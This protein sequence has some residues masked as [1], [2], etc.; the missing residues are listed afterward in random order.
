MQKSNWGD[1]F[2]HRPMKDLARFLTT[3]NMASQTIAADENVYDIQST[4]TGIC[5]INGVFIE[6]LTVDAAYPI[7][8]AQAAPTETTESWQL[9]IDAGV[10]T[11]AV[12]DEVY[13]GTLTGVSQKFYKCIEAHKGIEGTN[14]AE[15]TNLWQAIPNA[16]NLALAIDETFMAMVTAE[17]DGTL[18]VW[19]ACIVL[20]ASNAMPALIIPYFDP[21]VYCVVAFMEIDNTTNADTNSYGAVGTGAGYITH[22]SDA[23]FHQVIG[24]VFPHADNMPKN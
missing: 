19:I 6:T 11:F 10:T 9:L 21:S 24:P 20:G 12:D 18:G 14:P 1:L 16:H 4:G 8:T 3:Y 5:T 17:A 23:T 13:T 7:A 15:N 22:A 2:S